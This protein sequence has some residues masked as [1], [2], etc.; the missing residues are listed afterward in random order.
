MSNDVVVTPEFTPTNSNIVV[1]LPE[2]NSVV[3]FPLT[4]TGDAVGNWFFE[5]IMNVRI[6]DEDGKELGV[7][8]LQADGD[9]MTEDFVPFHLVIDSLDVGNAKSGKLVFEKA[10]PSGDPA[11][12]ESFEV[13]VKFE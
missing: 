2:V 6:F 1:S 5:A 7:W 13:A 11:R 10:N 3:S 4:I 9:W 8:N 12:D